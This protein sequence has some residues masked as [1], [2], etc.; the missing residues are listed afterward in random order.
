MLNL[1]FDIIKF[2]ISLKATKFQFDVRNKV[3]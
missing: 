3:F 2:D 1:S